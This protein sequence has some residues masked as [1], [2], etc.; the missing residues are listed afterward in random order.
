[1]PVR[2]ADGKNI[3]AKP[4]PTASKPQPNSAAVLPVR[5]TSHS[6]A[7]MRRGGATSDRPPPR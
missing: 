1:M 2:S 7:G 3:H 4:L 6:S 5:S